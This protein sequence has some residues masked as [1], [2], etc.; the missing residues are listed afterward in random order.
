MAPWADVLYACDEAWWKKYSGVP[1]FSGLKISHD[2]YRSP[3]EWNLRRIKIIRNDDRMHLSSFGV[4]GWGGN[5]GFHSLNLAAQFGAKRIVLV[6]FDMRLD[7]GLHWHGKHVSG[8]QNPTVTNVNRWRRCLDLAA[9]VL[10]DAGVEV[11][12]AS[13]QSALSAF[14]KMRLEEAID[15]FA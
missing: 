7:M 13:M 10:A 4:V 8:L 2:G 14:P 12:N 9:P 11:V 15:G 5:G 6:G 1:D 3:Q